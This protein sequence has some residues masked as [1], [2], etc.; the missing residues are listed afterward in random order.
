[1]PPLSKALEIGRQGVPLLISFRSGPGGCVGQILVTGSPFSS[2]GTMDNRPKERSFT[3][4]SIWRSIHPGHHPVELVVLQ[5]FFRYLS[6][7]GPKNGRFFSRE[8]HAGHL[9]EKHP[10][11][12]EGVVHSRH[13]AGPPA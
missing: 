3:V 11:G 2:L 10:V 7:S 13:T 5:V 6:P 1:M 12:I 9:I 4:S 8:P